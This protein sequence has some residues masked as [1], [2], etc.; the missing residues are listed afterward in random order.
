MTI[1]VMIARKIVAACG[2]DIRAIMGEQGNPAFNQALLKRFVNL[3]APRI[4]PDAWRRLW[5]PVTRAD[6]AEWIEIS[7]RSYAASGIRAGESGLDGDGWRL[8]RCEP[9]RRQGE[10]LA[11]SLDRGGG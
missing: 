8:C 9:S 3:I 4:E 10:P 11:G 1:A 5:G 7:G 6:L 2:R